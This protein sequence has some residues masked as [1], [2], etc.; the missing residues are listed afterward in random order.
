MNF[1]RQY[2]KV[3]PLPQRPRQ[4]H[5]TKTTT[6]PSAPLASSN[7]SSNIL[8]VEGDLLHYP[9]NYLVHQT[10]CTSTHARG[11][12]QHLFRQYPFANAYQTKICKRVAG[13][14]S[15][16]RDE[17]SKT[18]VVVNLYGQHYPGRGS[19][20][21]QKRNKTS[22]TSNDHHIR[23]DA[24]AR[25]TYFQHALL[26]LENQITKNKHRINSTTDP[27]TIAF[28][29]GIGCNLAGGDW[30]AYRSMLERF[31]TR[32]S[33]LSVVVVKLPETKM[34]SFHRTTGTSGSQLSTPS[35]T[36]PVGEF[37]SKPTTSKS[38]TSKSTPFKSTTFKKSRANAASST[39]TT[40]PTS[41][42]TLAESG[43]TN[44][45]GLR[46]TLLR[47]KFNYKYRRKKKQKPRLKADDIHA[48]QHFL[49]GT[50]ILF[51]YDP[52]SNNVS[53]T[54]SIAGTSIEFDGLNTGG[55]VIRFWLQWVVCKSGGRR[56]AL[57]TF[58][59]PS[60]GKACMLYVQAVMYT[61]K[62]GEWFT[63][64]G[65]D[66]NNSDAPTHSFVQRLLEKL[67]PMLGIS[68]VLEDETSKTNNGTP[69][70]TIT[71]LEDVAPDPSS[72]SCVEDNPLSMHMTDQ[73][74][75]AISFVKPK[76]QIVLTCEL[77]KD[78]HI[79]AMVRCMV[80][81]GMEVR[82]QTKKEKKIQVITICSKNKGRKKI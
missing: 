36:L 77:N 38:T 49:K 26:D 80:Q 31:A 46:V 50:N 39:S 35:S 37:K 12:A 47:A 44:V 2:Q 17:K 25:E 64:V 5:R 1:L 24:A 78:Y 19:N 68:F 14:V 73:L 70:F 10:N 56:G 16:H 65:G 18:L 81:D 60:D 28:P 58:T 29:Y 11:L 62:V 63:V 45:G 23:D 41:A 13:T 43:E 27:I 9:A 69:R 8:Q 72:W 21:K 3:K 76:F 4:R 15:F 61:L 66:P 57:E 52:A 40:A 34:N 54:T 75:M 48:Y 59:I 74:L 79:A 33:H 55:Q 7:A 51:D 67:R 6:A 82:V 71:R 42:S 30:V 53:F 20:K 32:N 22:T